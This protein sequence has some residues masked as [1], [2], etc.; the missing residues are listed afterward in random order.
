VKVAAST[1]WEILRNAG[2]DAAPLDRG[3]RRELLDRGLI[4]NQAICGGFE[5]APR[6]P[7]SAPG[8]SG[9]WRSFEDHLTVI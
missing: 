1:A 8:F 6:N 7:S 9:S 3:W 4:W 5:G 2:I